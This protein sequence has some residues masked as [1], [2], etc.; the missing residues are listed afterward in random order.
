MNSLSYKLNSISI[1]LDIN[2]AFIKHQEEEK[3]YRD[4]L[5]LFNYYYSLGDLQ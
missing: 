1:K 5:I 2:V 3:T 4:P